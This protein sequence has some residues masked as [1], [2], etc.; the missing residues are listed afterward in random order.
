MIL[1]TK[2]NKEVSVEDALDLIWRYHANG[3]Y[4]KAKQIA[5]DSGV[6][7]AAWN[8]WYKEKTDNNYVV[9]SG[10]GNRAGTVVNQN[11]IQAVM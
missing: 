7:D 2:R 6:T 9:S 4:A 10:S 11:Q 3:S 8:K 5:K 1:V